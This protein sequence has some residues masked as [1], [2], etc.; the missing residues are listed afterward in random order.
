MLITLYINTN[1][2]NSMQLLHADR[3]AR[4]RKRVPVKM[5]PVQ[6]VPVRPAATARRTW[7]ARQFRPRAALRPSGQSPRRITLRRE[8]SRNQD[9]GTLD[10]RFDASLDTLPVLCKISVVTGL[11]FLVRYTRVLWRLCWAWFIFWI[12]WSRSFVSGIV[13]L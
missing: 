1:K 10:A 6:M 11:K 2:T 8:T 12:A 9:R 4:E 13:H 7:K 3:T 5:G